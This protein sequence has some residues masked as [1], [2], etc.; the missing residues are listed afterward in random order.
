MPSPASKY[1]NDDSKY[2]RYTSTRTVK[3]QAY[4][5]K[6]SIKDEYCRTDNMKAKRK[7]MRNGAKAKPTKDYIIYEEE[8]DLKD[9]LDCNKGYQDI[10]ECDDDHCDFD[11]D[12][13]DNGSNDYGYDDN[14]SYG[15]GGNNNSGDGINVSNDNNEYDNG[16]YGVGG[17]NN[18]GGGSNF[19]ND[20]NEKYENGGGRSIA[21]MYKYSTSYN[22]DGSCKNDST[23]C[24]DDALCKNDSCKDDDKLRISKQKT[25]QN[26]MNSDYNG[27]R[28]SICNMRPNKQKLK[29]KHERLK[30]KYNNALF[31]L[32][33]I[34]QVHSIDYI[35]LRYNQFIWSQRHDKNNKS[36]CEDKIFRRLYQKYMRNKKI[37]DD[38]RLNNDD[39]NDN[40]N[41]GYIDIENDGVKHGVVMN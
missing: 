39:N 6:P 3:I 1:G 32:N 38:Y 22:G 17:D 41:W 31:T 7:G 14:G 25:K 35:K 30:Q 20:N 18:N 21:N 40:Y 9:E 5:R 33:S 8:Y 34:L 11:N 2:Y 23:S 12:C 37:I 24:R 36:S 10:I 19:S 15:V 27:D 13:D 29:Q 26:R 16:G 28:R 4:H